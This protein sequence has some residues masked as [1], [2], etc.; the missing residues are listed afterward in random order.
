MADLTPKQEK[1]IA[2]LLASPTIGE[3]AAAAGVGARTLHTWL[4]DPVF[5]A[6]YRT[7][8]RDAVGQA[9]ARLQQLS[10]DA[11][12]T[13]AGLLGDSRPTI[14]LAAASKVLDLAVRG[15]ELDDLAA[16]IAELEACIAAPL[17][18]DR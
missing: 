15:I 3:A 17:D 13:L 7:A 14:R 6:A 18:S 16:R 11:V 5:A 12:A 10:G 8:R 9:I 4:A 2:A 1:T